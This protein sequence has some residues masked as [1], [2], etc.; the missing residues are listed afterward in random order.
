MC[1]P[2]DVDLARALHAERDR[3][4]EVENRLTLRAPVTPGRSTRSRR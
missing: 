4:L 3:E 2:L 1:Y